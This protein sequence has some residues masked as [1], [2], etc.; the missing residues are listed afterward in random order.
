MGKITFEDDPDVQAMRAS[1]RPATGSLRW[2]KVV[3]GVVVVACATFAL[4]YHLPL[5][6]AHAALAESFAKAQ[7]QLSESSRALDEARKEARAAMDKQRAIEG[8]VDQMKE[9]DKARGDASRAAKKALEPKLQKLLEKN[10]AALGVTATS[11]VVSLS[12]A[13]VLVPG[14]I[15]VSPAGKTTLCSIVGTSQDK[16]IRVV[17]IADKKSIPAG[18]AAKLKTPLQLN[19][20]VAQS[21]TETLLK[22]NVAAGRL[23]AVGMP[24]EPPAPAKLEG[25]VLAG[26]RIELWLD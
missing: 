23:S 5:Q 9:A 4:G 17:A 26:S 25:K 11:A 3:T 2:G 13:A 20:A 19:L 1:M 14:K 16:P 15:D 24:A 18:L 7:S 10:Q 8:Q 22:C 6:R 21:V 12:H